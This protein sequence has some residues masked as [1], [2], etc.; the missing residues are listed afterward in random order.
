MDSLGIV[1]S[2]L[3]SICVISVLLLVLYLDYEE[4]Y[5]FVESFRFEGW[6]KLKFKIGDIQ[7]D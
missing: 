1:S 3:S 7:F 4:K 5:I 2:P 6:R